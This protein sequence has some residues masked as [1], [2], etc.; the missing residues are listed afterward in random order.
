MVESIQVSNFPKT[1]FIVAFG[2]VG[3]KT[4]FV[5]VFVAGDTIF[6]FHPLPILKNSERRCVEVMAFLTVYLFVLSFERKQRFA[7]V[8]LVQFSRPRERLF[9]VAFLAVGAQVVFV[10]V[11]VAT[12]AVGK[13]HAGKFLKLRSVSCFFQ[14]AFDAGHGIVFSSQWKIRFVV[15]KPASR[16]ECV[17]GMAFGAIVSQRF[18]VA[19][20][21]A[22]Q[23]VLLQAQK[24]SLPFFQSRIGYV[25]RL[26][27]FPAVCFFVRADQ[28]V[29]GFG[30]VK[31][32]FI[33]SNHVK[34][35]SVVF[36]VAS[37][38]ILVPHF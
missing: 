19:V 12:V 11:G 10:C 37:R 6:R 25:V 14:M 38:T 13:C 17:A 29:A 9:R 28:V 3:S 4:A 35:P 15:I 26:V 23:A 30:V 16:L 27:A 2:A 34:L 5:Y 21:V 1:V 36:A 8:K 20:F 31:R 7:V 32:F 24:R 22:S 18:L 33:E